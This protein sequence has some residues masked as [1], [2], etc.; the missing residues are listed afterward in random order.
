MFGGMN[1][2]VNIILFCC[3]INLFI[4]NLVVE[5]YN[6]LFTECISHSTS[7]TLIFDIYEK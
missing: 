1:I 6:L 5:F 7:T 2:R 3:I 4:D